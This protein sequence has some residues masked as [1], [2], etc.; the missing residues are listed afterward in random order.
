MVALLRRRRGGLRGDRA[1]ARQRRSLPA[2]LEYLDGGRARRARRP[3]SRAACP[4]APGFARAS[5]RPTARAAEAA[6]LRDELVEALGEARSPSRRRDAG[7]ARAVALARRRLVA[8]TR[9]A[10]RQGERGR[11][12]A[13]WTGC[14]GARGDARR[15]ARG[16]GSRRCSWGHA[17]DGNL[18]ATFLVDPATS[19][20]LE[21]ARGAPPRTV[22]RWPCGSAASV[23]GEHGVGAGQARGARR[24]V[25][26]GA[27]RAHEAIKRAFDPKGLL[28]PGK[29][30]A[31]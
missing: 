29:K 17:G 10:R 31:R 30:V 4:P 13:R 3:R 26:R 1:R 12:R 28:N 14:R 11:R 19:R 18:H 25:G 23:S 16:T 2:A 9:A 8:V 5:P 15:S 7:D 22:R 24:A 20:E 27:L 21:R 6:R